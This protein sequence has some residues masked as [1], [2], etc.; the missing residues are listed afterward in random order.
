MLKRKLEVLLTTKEQRLHELREELRTI[1][2]DCAVLSEVVKCDETPFPNAENMYIAVNAARPQVIPHDHIWVSCRTEPKT[3]RLERVESH[4]PCNRETG[5][6]EGAIYYNGTSRPYSNCSSDGDIGGL[7]F[8]P[9]RLVFNGHD[10]TGDELLE[11]YACLIDPLVF[12]R[13]HMR[14][15]IFQEV[16][17][18][19]L[20]FVP[21]LDVN[22]IRFVLCDYLE[23]ADYSEMFRK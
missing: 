1:C 18:A 6:F 2:N 19:I 5:H 15:L 14:R 4:Q 12:C 17:S 8:L 11:L 20:H 21:T 23:K 16:T 22:V 10:V 3:F 9:V 7:N 13:I